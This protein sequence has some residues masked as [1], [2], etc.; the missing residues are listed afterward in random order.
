[1]KNRNS[2]GCAKRV[3]HGICNTSTPILAHSLTAI[4]PSRIPGIGHQQ[5]HSKRCFDFTCLRIY[6]DAAIAPG[7]QRNTKAF[8]FRLSGLGRPCNLCSFCDF[9][10]TLQHT[11]GH[12]SFFCAAAGNSLMVATAR[13]SIPRLVF[14]PRAP[15]SRLTK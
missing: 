11:N 13:A 4:V 3:Q 12:R 14:A 6:G 8:H 15:Q 9:G 5:L 1:M 2:W 7:L 10:Q